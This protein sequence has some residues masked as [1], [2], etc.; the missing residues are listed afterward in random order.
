MTLEIERVDFDMD[1]T[2]LR[3]LGKN[4]EEN[5]AIKRGQY[6]TLEVQTNHVITLKKHFYD[7]DFEEILQE[8]TSE[9]QRNSV[10]VLVMQFGLAN[11]CLVSSEATMTIVHVERKI[12]K[13]RAYVNGRDV[14][15]WSFFLDL[16]AHLKK[17]L[18]KL[19]FKPVV[20]IG[21]YLLHSLQLNELIR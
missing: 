7:D 19:S 5:K 17:L 11:L 13:K 16:H 2:S 20:I 4:C 18:V 1:T 15:I 14:A 21:R 3:V 10:I 12:P 6:H 8:I 9:K